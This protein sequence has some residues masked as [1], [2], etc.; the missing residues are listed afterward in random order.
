MNLKSLVILVIGIGIG[1][2]IQTALAKGV[3]DKVVISSPSLPHDIV[4]ENDTCM[5]NALALG[6]LEDLTM[7]VNGTPKVEGNGYLV[8][9]YM[10]QSDGSYLPFDQARFYRDPAGGYMYIHDLGGIESGTAG[11]W[12]R[13]TTFTESLL[14]NLLL[15]PSS[16]AT[17]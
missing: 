13:P 8:T 2:G 9:R 14:E 15:S 16:W 4:I 7:Q 5:L 12:F 11:E 6:N 10:K 3:P 1:I 17:K